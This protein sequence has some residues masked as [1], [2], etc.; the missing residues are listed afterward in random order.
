MTGWTTVL[1]AL[2]LMACTESRTA[3][4]FECPG[5]GDVTVRKPRPDRNS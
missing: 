4:L 5:L 2:A 1:A 3:F